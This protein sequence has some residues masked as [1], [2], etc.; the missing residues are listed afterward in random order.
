MTRSP[1]LG[2]IAGLTAPALRA[3]MQLFNA[4][5]A[6][7][8]VDRH[9][10]NVIS[11]QMRDE[12]VVYE[13]VSDRHM[14]GS[15]PTSAGSAPSLPQSISQIRGSGL[16]EKQMVQEFV[17]DFAR[18]AV[19][20]VQCDLVDESTGSVFQG[21]YYID[22]AMQRL[23]FRQ[24]RTES[25]AQGLYR[26]IEMARI[27]DVYDLEAGESLVL[28]GKG[29]VPEVVLTSLG[30]ESA[31]NRLAIIALEDALA[32][33][34]LLESSTVDR[35]RFIMCVKILKLYAQTHGMATGGFEVFSG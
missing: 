18:C 22:V 20:G 11:P 30:H 9:E 15:P 10:E 12:K 25:N 24:G 27:H 4:C 32:P 6:C 29:V 17:K 19:R 35:D 31:R 14:M 7:D 33:V 3:A 16:P 2:A 26:E 1:A 21:T 8:H 34:C 23:T 28:L 5:Q 13:P